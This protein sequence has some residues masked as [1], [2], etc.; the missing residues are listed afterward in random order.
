MAKKPSRSDRWASAVTEDKVLRL[1]ARLAKMPSFVRDEIA[2]LKA[3]I[4]G[5]QEQLASNP[6][7]NVLIPHYPDPHYP[8]QGN[9]GL[10]E[11]S[12]IRF[13]VDKKRERH[14]DV[15]H[16]RHSKAGEL[17]TLRG[18]HGQLMV[19]PNASNTITLKMGEYE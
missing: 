17:I 3:E 18:S 4:T 5:L 12:T 16:A 6:G 2:R 9:R 13:V 15:S 7:S 8:D 10:P 14:I 11:N 1:K 19:L